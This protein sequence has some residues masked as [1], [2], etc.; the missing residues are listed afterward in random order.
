MK[1]L[2]YILAGILAF[3]LM[4]FACR[5]CRWLGEAKQVAY[6][7]VRPREL[8]RKYEW[9]KDASAAL[10][11]LGANVEV[12]RSNMRGLE[13]TGPRN[14]W[15]SDDRRQYNQ[16]AT[17]VAGVTAQYNRLASEYNAQMAKI[18]WAFC[19]VGELP[20]GATQ[21][22]PREYREYKEN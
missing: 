15:A 4:S 1:Y 21:V 10:D 6:N 11:S 20:D 16:W 13:Q 3:I 17:E 14:T 22:L 8:L 12:Y 9:F 19:N 18:N 2:G 7:E 5:T